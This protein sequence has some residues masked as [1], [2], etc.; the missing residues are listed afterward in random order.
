MVFIAPKLNNKTATIERQVISEKM[1]KGSDSQPAKQPSLLEAIIEGFVD[2]VLII[3]ERGDWV[4][5]ND[6]ARRICYQL[7]QNQSQVNLVPQPIWQIC[8]SLI[9]SR[10]IFPDQSI[11][12]EDEIDADDTSAFRI[13][14][15]W[16]AFEETSQPY[17]LV[18]MEDKL[19][20]TQNAAFAEI[21]KFNLTSR[22]AE[23]W[24]LRRANYSYKEIAAKLYI[25]HNT[26]KKHLKNIYAKQQEMLWE[27]E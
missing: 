2:G 4:H 23:V 11:I 13:R 26:V 12:I 10:E 15:R 7:D 1:V 27:E 17:I 14:A 22:E 8:E 21:K 6:R 20:S 19:Q 25:T 18:T 16:F 3:T 24:L 5:G 9:D